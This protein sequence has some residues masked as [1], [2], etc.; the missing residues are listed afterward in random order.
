MDSRLRIG[1]EYPQALPGAHTGSSTKSRACGGTGAFANRIAFADGHTQAHEYSEAYKNAQT[2]QDTQADQD[3][4][5]HAAA[6][7]IAYASPHQ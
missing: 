6:Q 7:R 2:N 5:A 3:T 1:R 4:H